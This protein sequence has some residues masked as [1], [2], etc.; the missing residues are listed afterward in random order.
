VL[1]FFYSLGLGVPFIAAGVALPWV[2]SAAR[3]VRDHWWLVT[4][5]SG[6]LLVV[7][8]VL[9]WSGQLTDLSARLAG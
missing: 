7:M 4:R 5:A 9:L 6:A 8:G 2:L 3:T 1:L